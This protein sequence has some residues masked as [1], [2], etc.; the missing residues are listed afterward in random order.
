MRVNGK[1]QL[2][3]YMRIVLCFICGIV[4]G[5]YIDGV[6]TAV[7]LAVSALSL[8]VA[9]AVPA[10][11]RLRPGMPM[12]VAK[13]GMIL[14]TVFCLGGLRM[15]LE[16]DSMTVKLPPTTT[17]YQAVV[18]SPPIEKEKIVMCDLKVLRGPDIDKPL[19]VKAS[20][21]KP[22]Y[23]R[24]RLP[25]VP[26]FYYKN[27]I[28]KSQISNLKLHVGDGMEVFS[29]LT[30]PTNFI[31]SDFDYALFLKRRGFAAT[32]F[33]PADSWLPQ[34]VSLEPLSYI[35]R[36]RIGALRL[37]Q[38]IS[39]RYRNLG[40]GGQE[41]AVLSA[42]T[43]G[44]KSLLD[45]ETKELYSA[46]G[47]SHVLA[48][49]GLHLGI[50]YSILTLLT[51]GG[52]WRRVSQVLI[53]L[54]IWTYVVMVGLSLSVVRSALM[55][56]VF[57]FAAMLGR[58]NFSVNSLSVSALVMLGINPNNLFDVGFQMS[59]MAVMSILVLY[60]DIYGWLPERWLS[61][62]AVSWAWGMAA[63]S[64][65][66]Q[67]GVAPLIAY[68]FH[69]LSM[70]FLPVN[71]IVVPAATVILY[72]A[73]L[74]LFCWPLLPLQALLAKILSFVVSLLNAFLERV[75]AWPHASIDD[76]YPTLLQV[77]CLYV[78]IAAM[79]VVLHYLALAWRYS[80]VEGFV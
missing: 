58:N 1:L 33:I 42:M 53:L 56:T 18:V 71:Y 39:D 68:Y 65:A 8:A 80:R 69:R 4:A 67:I 57:S 11:K 44:D 26:P 61:H 41:L 60:K 77:F 45:A 7:W 78:F 79:Y 54:A 29:T 73:V 63:V 76:L 19:L 49:S 48:L 37:R 16:R 59:F 10:G 47:A 50:I 28:L 23:N 2:V 12:E 15:A 9:F 5:W 70:Y 46:T 20:F 22:E 35:E 64:I 38:R 40:I 21:L 6:A 32:T 14:L 36:T 74:F 30:E 43:V 55:L 27:L 52:R 75:A 3:P 66:A 24:T 31:E 13:G 51:I 17:A 72:C 62:K 25:E 34:Q